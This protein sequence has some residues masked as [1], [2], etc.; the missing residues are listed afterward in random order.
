MKIQKKLIFMIEDNKEVQTVLA[1]VKANY[2]TNGTINCEEKIT[3]VVYRINIEDKLRNSL[4]R[5]IVS[6]EF[7]YF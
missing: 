4:Y 1:Y 6:K 2:L 3:N 5:D 7:K